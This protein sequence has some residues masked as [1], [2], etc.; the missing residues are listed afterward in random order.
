MISIDIY[1]VFARLFEKKK[2]K[3]SE[4][5]LAE[6]INALFVEAYNGALSKKIDN[7]PLRS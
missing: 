3:N 4:R 6:K 7:N 1:S 2:K 5:Q